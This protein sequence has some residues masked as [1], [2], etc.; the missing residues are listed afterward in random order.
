MLHLLDSHYGLGS[1][2][3]VLLAVVV[4]KADLLLHPAV[5][6]LDRSEVQLAVPGEYY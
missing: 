5:A 3:V 4:A 6:L 2:G 1:D